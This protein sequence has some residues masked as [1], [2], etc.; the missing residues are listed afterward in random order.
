[1]WEVKRL[2]HWV[3]SYACLYIHRH[4]HT[5]SYSDN[6]FVVCCRP[7]HPSYLLITSTTCATRYGTL[8]FGLPSNRLQTHAHTHTP[9]YTDN[10]RTTV[11]CNLGLTT[12]PLLSRNCE[13]LSGWISTCVVSYTRGCKH[14]NDIHI[15]INDIHSSFCTPVVVVA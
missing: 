3:R 2:S 9:V 8:K 7:T 14:Y 1:M 12:D 13:A 11:T 15:F 6:C 5:L 10:Q 4:T